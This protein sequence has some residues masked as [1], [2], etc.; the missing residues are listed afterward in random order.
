MKILFFVWEVPLLLTR[1]TGARLDHD[2]GCLR[3]G[4]CLLQFSDSRWLHC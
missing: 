2:L 4:L 3:F 1:N